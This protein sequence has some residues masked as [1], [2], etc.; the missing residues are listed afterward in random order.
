MHE[1]QL[2][3][4]IYRYCRSVDLFSL[5]TINDGFHIFFSTLYGYKHIRRDSKEMEK[6]RKCDKSVNIKHRAAL[7]SLSHPI[8]EWWIIPAVSLSVHSVQSQHNGMEW[9]GKYKSLARFLFVDVCVQYAIVY[10]WNKR[11]SKFKFFACFI[12]FLE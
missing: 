1:F 3:N 8:L 11:S 5:S 12:W 9:D 6:N 4:L 7:P 2:N 10:C